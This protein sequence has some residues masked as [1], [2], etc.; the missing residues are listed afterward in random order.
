MMICEL[1]HAF[2]NLHAN[3]R[4]N[5]EVD[6]IFPKVMM[7]SDILEEHDDETKNGDSDRRIWRRNLVP[8]SAAAPHSAQRRA[9][10]SESV[11]N[12]DE[13][14]VSLDPFLCLR[15]HSL[16]LIRDTAA[17]AAHE[18]AFV[19]RALLLALFCIAAVI[20]FSTANLLE[21]GSNS[22]AVK[23]P[24]QPQVSIRGLGIPAHHSIIQTEKLVDGFM[25]DARRVSSPPLLPKL[26]PRPS[27]SI[28][29][30]FWL[31][32]ESSAAPAT[33]IVSG[34]GP[35]P[36]PADTQ[37]PVQASAETM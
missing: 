18:R 36:G 31:P 14:R 10:A 34:C 26:K 3:Y 25:D 8:S 4:Q 7:Y 24:S 2:P 29:A 33:S 30:S 35:A 11:T 22:V 21:Y 12:E 27:T 32:A 37:R 23:A 13:V 16:E 5:A 6:Y 20:I 15:A 9:A 28:G 19:M 17:T 1:P